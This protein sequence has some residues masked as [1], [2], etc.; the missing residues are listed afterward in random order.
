[1]NVWKGGLILV[2]SAIAILWSTQISSSFVEWMSPGFDRNG[3]ISFLLEKPFQA[4]W[5]FVSSILSQ[6][7]EFIDRF[8]GLSGYDPTVLPGI[9]KEAHAGLICA[10]LLLLEKTSWVKW[11]KLWITFMILGIWLL[12]D[13]A[14][15][16][17]F[18]P[19][20]SLVMHGVQGRYLTPLFLVVAWILPKIRQTSWNEEQIQSATCY[21][22]IIF[23]VIFALGIGYYFR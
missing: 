7:S 12:T 23:A 18:T 9:L 15:Y 4:L 13:L 6:P 1:M 17:T 22:N 10:L 20:G 3:Q 2:I 8:F 11:Q 16:V 21:C 5:I 19:V 14:L